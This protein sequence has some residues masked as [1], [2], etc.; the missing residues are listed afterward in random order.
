[1]AD[2][3]GA[4]EGLLAD[5]EKRPYYSGKI[6]PDLLDEDAPMA[7]RPAGPVKFLLLKQFRAVVSLCLFFLSFF[8]LIII[9]FYY[10]CL[11]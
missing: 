2:E 7:R 1:M 11:F 6:D 9:L 10:I 3:P 8:S 4:N 5:A